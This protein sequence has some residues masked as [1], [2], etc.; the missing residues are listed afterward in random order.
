MRAATNSTR[1]RYRAAARWSFD[2]Y[3]K[4][5]DGM[6]DAEELEA[7]DREQLAAEE[8]EHRA[9]DGG[10]RRSGWTEMGW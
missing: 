3:D 8:R 4:N 2:R 1:L 10:G 7:R 5:R 9:A 6:L